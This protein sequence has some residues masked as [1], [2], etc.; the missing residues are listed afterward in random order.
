MGQTERTNI[1]EI[2]TQG[3]T[4]GPMLCSN[5]IDTV[6]KFALENGHHFLYKNL[7]RVIPLAMVDDLLSMSSCGFESTAINTSI[8]TIIE[9]KKLQFHIPEAGKKS[10]CHFMH[11]GK[12]NKYCP[13]MKVHG[14]Q[15]DRVEEA[16][17]LGD[18]I[19]AD[20]KNSSN[21]ESRVNKGIGQISQIM[22]ILK[23]VSFGA[24]Y[25]KIAVT[26]RETMFINGILTNADV[27][28]GLLKSEIDQ[29]EEIDR[30]L[31]R[32]ILEVPSSSCV[33]SL[34]LELGITPI[35]VILKAR[36]VN[37]LHYLATLK[38]DEMLY[39]VFKAQW[40]NPVKDDWTL[41]VKRNLEELNIHLSLEEIQ[42]KS[43]N[44]FKNLIK[45][46]AKEFAL[47]YLLN[48][49]ERHEKM[50]NLHYT[51]LEIQNYLHDPKIPAAEAK[52]LFR[53]RTRIAKFKANMKNGY[54]TITCPLCS[55]QPDTQVHSMQCQEVKARIKIE[56]DYKDIFTKHIP[57]NISKTL[58]RIS[59]LRKD[60]L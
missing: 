7:A 2:T 1:P 17:Y 13:G 50:E 36:R 60:L 45:T 42:K 11:I 28:Y 49:S 25:F 9:L 12:A 47:D 14:H 40:D 16:V 27:W 6:G 32:G 30:M 48:L 38:D 22:D 23:T 53:F 37:Y 18:N 29:L 24:Q 10:K 44:S 8:N 57:S 33:E 26:L 4:W 20:G 55:V 21:I 3:G 52:N 35:H 31:I 15:A 54:S 19:R 46:R 58:L 41:E 43:T 5:S 51:D 34:Y 39:R 56:G 59:E